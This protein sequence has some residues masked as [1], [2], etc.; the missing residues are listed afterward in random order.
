MGDP[1]TVI[2]DHCTESGVTRQT[3]YRRVAPDGGLR[4]TGKSYWT[5]KR[6]HT[7]GSRHGEFA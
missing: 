4:P 3:L 7:E 5:A 2:R 1:E 6:V